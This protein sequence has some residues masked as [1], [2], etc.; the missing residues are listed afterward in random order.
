MAGA[1]LRYFAL[2]KRIEKLLKEPQTSAA[3]A[4]RIVDELYRALPHYAVIALFRVEGDTL[5]AEARHGLDPPQAQTLATGVAATILST[6][7]SLLLIDLRRDQRA[8]PARESIVAELVVPVIRH[9]QTVQVFDIQSDRWGVLGRA[10]QELI[11]W[12]AMRLA[13]QSIDTLTE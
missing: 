2:R 1:N 3:L 7:R 10:D 13:G 12:I 11:E 9:G 8:R 4:Q 5:K 6:N